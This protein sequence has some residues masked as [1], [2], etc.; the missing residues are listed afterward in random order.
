MGGST[1]RIVHGL[2]RFGSLPRQVASCA[3]AHGSAAGSLRFPD[4]LPY[5]R[6]PFALA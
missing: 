5:Q 6:Q 3:I 1:T 2:G 4:S